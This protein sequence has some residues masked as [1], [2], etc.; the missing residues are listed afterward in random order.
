MCSKTTCCRR[1]RK[2]CRWREG[3]RH[4]AFA[5]VGGT[6]AAA[7]G[8]VRPSQ[9][10]TER[11]PFRDRFIRWVLAHDKA[12]LLVAL[13]FTVVAGWL[14]SRLVVD[15]DL[16]RLL[17]TDHP[18]VVS[19]ERFEDTFG[20]T[21]SVNV[22]IANG[23]VEGR[24]AFADAVAKALDGHVR[25]DG[26]DYRLP[27]QFFAEHALYYLSDPEM[28]ELQDKVAAWTHYEYCTAAP[29][30]CV[31][32]PDPGAPDRLR[33]FIDQKRE[34]SFE[35]T[36]FEDYYEKEG[37]DA[38]VVLLRPTQHSSDLAFATA[39]TAEM[40]A[41]V[42]KVFAGADAPWAGTGMRY[43]LVGPYIVK[44]D[45]HLTIQRDMVRSGAV[46]LGG[47]ILILYLLFRSGRAVVTLLV[48][49]LCGVTWSLA[50]TQLIL[51]HL[52]S[53]TSLISTVVMG[54]GIDAGIHFFSRA[55]RNRRNLADA[56]AIRLA[57]HGLIVPLLVASSTT[58]G[59]FLVMASSRFPMFRE[60]G[61]IAA[62]GVVL[63]LSSMVTVLPALASVVGIKRNPRQRDEAHI[64]AA[65]RFI[66]ARPGALFAA[67]VLLTVVSFQGVRHVAFE[68]DG[69]TL[70]SDSARQN[71][72]ADTNLISEI[73]G[74]DI[75]AGVYVTDDLERA[76]EALERAR[77]RRDARS[78]V[79]GTVVAELFGASDL[80]PEADLDL[81]GRRE[82]I[83][84]LAEDIPETAWDR[85]E[86]RAGGVAP[87]DEK[88]VLTPKDARLLRR[89]LDAQPFG[90]DDLPPVI[91]RKV[92][93]EDGH[94]G[95]FAY[96]GFDAANIERGVRFMAETS[97]Y[98][99]EPDAQ[100]V[101]ETTVYAAM[102]LMLRKEAPVVLGMAAVL[103]A[104]LVF[105][106]LRSVSQ[107]LLTLLPL[108]LALWWLVALMGAVD[109]RFTLFNLPILPA[110]L[111][112]GVDNGVY[113]TDRIRRSRGE[114][115]GLAH[116]LQET[117]GAILAATAT[118]A[119]GFAAFMVADSGGLRGIGHLAVLGILMAAAAA[120]LVLPT[121]SAIGQRRRDRRG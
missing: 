60:F 38:L 54:V 51:G 102:Y 39:V 110:I 67:L 9:S 85:I 6:L 77:D 118:T 97:T 73:F 99:G 104:A 89:M 19:L 105:W 25:L 53:M 109:L 47:V 78:R 79:E 117:G 7:R 16:R 31:E 92:R 80:L 87:V 28:D 58:M 11:E 44:A 3:S 91:L 8:P 103:I 90:P 66:L 75:H 35:R 84:E 71:T 4:R 96:P 1:W 116:S 37:V 70:Q 42:H 22:V 72:E 36:G 119:V 69:R 13:A 120:V 98:L 32:D 30:V 101:G 93:A 5:A 121:L 10:L 83:E 21:G 17:P 55:R 26:V 27:S 107:M 43:N 40:R 94:Y 57:F 74:K 115:N 112:I 50:A 20:S 63:C 14:T 114:M 29:D 48:P 64:G 24:R 68:Y 15:S 82:R 100:F 88:K 52:N 12:V 56:D 111:G 18:V 106:Q 34:Q 46:A 113:L 59:A 45:G 95:V 81:Q 86:K 41:E 49:L 61:I 65:T 62:M 108:G 76:R 23:T 33:D 2:P